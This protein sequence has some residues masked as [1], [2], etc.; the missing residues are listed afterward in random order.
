MHTVEHKFYERRIKN[1]VDNLSELFYEKEQDIALSYA[2]FDSLTVFGEHLKSEYQT[3]NAGEEWGQNWQNVWFK[4]EGTIPPRFSES[5]V[6]LHVDLGGEGCLYSNSGTALDAFSCHSVFAPTYFRDRYIIDN[7]TLA[8]GKFTYW[9]D[10]SASWIFGGQVPKNPNLN[11]PLRFGDYRAKFNY[12]KIGIFR[13][14]IW[15]LHLDLVILSELMF[16]L[17]EKSVRRS[18]IRHQIN[19]AIHNFS[20]SAK[21]VEVTRQKLQSLLKDTNSSSAL[22]TVAIGHAHID[23]A[24][25]WPY[26]ESIKKCART[27]SAQLNLLDQY[28]SYRFGAS[29]AQH[30][31]FVKKHYPELYA[32]IKQKVAEKKFEI[33]GAMWV[34]SDCNLISGESLVRQLIHGKKFFAD[35]FGINVRNL[36]LPDVFGYSAALPQILSLAEVDYMVTQKLS[37]NRYNKFPYHSFVWRGIDGSEVITH[38]PPEDQYDSELAPV[39]LRYA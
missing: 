30:F 12:A 37:W 22:T 34:E 27:F 1:F 15:Q 19:E 2:K 21:Q 6:V 5:E 8:D 11:D 3:I 10:G 7:Q 25:L 35:E 13:S 29:Q 26:R 18:R 9:I 23:T 14:D 33:Q 24:W 38:F 39:N 16:D 4:L 28:P 32:R 36:W 31:A 20:S 17:P